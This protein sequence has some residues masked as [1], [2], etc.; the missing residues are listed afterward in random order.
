MREAL[1]FAVPKADPRYKKEKVLLKGDIADPANPPSGCYFH[2]RCQ[3]AQEICKNK[4]PPFIN[5][6]NEEN[7]HYVACHFADK[8]QLIGIEKKVV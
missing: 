6:S 1:L 5:I 7:A 8:L 2:P 3:Y 4:E